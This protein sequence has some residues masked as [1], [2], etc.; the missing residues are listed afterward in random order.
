MAVVIK[1]ERFIEITKEAGFI[2]IQ[3][4]KT[5]YVTVPKAIVDRLLEKHNINLKDKQNGPKIICDLAKEGTDTK[6]VYLLC[7]PNV[8]KENVV[9]VRTKRT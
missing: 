2:I 9:E 3:P 7:N 5:V 6:L 4:S 1:R 8:Q